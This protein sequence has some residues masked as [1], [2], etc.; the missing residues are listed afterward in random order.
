MTNGQDSGQYYGE[1]SKLKDLEEKQRILKERIL[2]IGETLID[3]KEKNDDRF[4]EI[5]KDIEEIKQK[6]PNTIKMSA[7]KYFL[8]IVP[9][10]SFS[11]LVKY[12]ASANEWF[13]FTSFRQL[14]RHGSRISE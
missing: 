14:K 4:L 1:V 12:K 10:Q 2:L 11:V 8:L 13:L 5:K 9:L 7:A 6:I 3:V